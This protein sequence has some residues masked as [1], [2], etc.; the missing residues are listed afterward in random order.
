MDEKSIGE[1][2]VTSGAVGV[3]T[4]S[5]ELQLFLFVSEHYSFTQMFLILHIHITPRNP[6]WATKRK[7]MVSDRQQRP[8]KLGG[9][10]IHVP[11]SVQALQLLGKDSCSLRDA[12]I[13]SA[14]VLISTHK[15]PLLCIVLCKHIHT[16]THR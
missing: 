4:P 12:R 11:P 13:I 16:H 7:E 15:Q 8:R 1:T 14:L 3:G 6:K 9:Q 5:Q 10:G 2:G